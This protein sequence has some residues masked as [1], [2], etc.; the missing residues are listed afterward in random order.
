MIIQS[1]IALDL[2]RPKLIAVVKKYRAN[3]TVQ[4]TVDRE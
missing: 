3:L 4:R 1:G 2:L